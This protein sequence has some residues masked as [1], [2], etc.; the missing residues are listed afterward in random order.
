MCNL[1]SW[2]EWLADFGLRNPFTKESVWEGINRVE[3]RLRA[4]VADRELVGNAHAAVF[5]PDEI[6]ARLHAQ[7]QLFRLGEQK[8]RAREEKRALLQDLRSQRRAK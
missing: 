3:R 2:I 7:H 1:H 6:T 8:K 4:P 5:T